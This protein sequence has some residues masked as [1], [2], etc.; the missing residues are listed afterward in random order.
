MFRSFCYF[1]VLLNF[2]QAQAYDYFLGTMILLDAR[3]PDREFYLYYTLIPK[4]IQSSLF[5]YI[6]L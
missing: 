5:I 4:Q 1:F 2:L 6:Y 3:T